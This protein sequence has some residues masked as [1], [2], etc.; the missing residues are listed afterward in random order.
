[1]YKKPNILYLECKAIKGNTLN[2]K[3]H[4]RENQWNGLTQKLY[5]DGAKAGII[6]WFIDLDETYYI[7]IY[8]LNWMLKVEHKL[9]FN[10]K[11]DFDRA[12]LIEGKKRRV[13]F[14]YNL[15]EFMEVIFDE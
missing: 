5:I 6:C 2:F 7:P 8:N 3:S 15:K 1:M 10:A 9:S 11:T 13:F 4:I 12:Y 14:D